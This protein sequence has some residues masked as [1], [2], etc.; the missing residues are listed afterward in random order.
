MVRPEEIGE[1]IAAHPGLV[2][3]QE[4]RDLKGVIHVSCI[5]NGEHVI[6]DFSVRISLPSGYP[7]EVPSVFASGYSLPNG[8]SHVFV[9]NGQLCLGTMADQRFF[10][11]EG[12]SLNEWVESYVVPFFFSTEYFR[13]YGYSPF[14]E[15][16]HGFKGTLEYYQELF[17]LD[18]IE[19]AFRFLELIATRNYRGSTMCPCNSGKQIRDCHRVVIQRYSAEMYKEQILQDY[20]DVLLQ[21]Q[22]AVEHIAKRR[23]NGKNS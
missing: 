11:A 4:L 22:K 10:I 12:H 20:S 13:K 1:V 7:H 3:F 2:Y 6:G 17:G 21:K 5:E 19:S 18:N 8:Y 23:M 9:R 15:R 16:S 14:G